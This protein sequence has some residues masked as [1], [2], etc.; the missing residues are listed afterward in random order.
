MKKFLMVLFLVGC[1]SDA[2]PEFSEVSDAGVDADVV[3]VVNDNPNPMSGDVV[4]PLMR[5]QEMCFR[6]S[7]L[8]DPDCERKLE[9]LCYE[10]IRAASGPYRWHPSFCQAGD[11][12]ACELDPVVACRPRLLK[13]PTDCY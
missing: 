8:D 1:S 6:T 12:P 4:Q 7:L 3:P 5:Q 11:C 9:S 13:L 2:D 10:E